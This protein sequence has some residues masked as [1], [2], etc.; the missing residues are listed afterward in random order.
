MNLPMFLTFA[1]G[2]PQD[3]KIKFTFPYEFSVRDVK[4]EKILKYT[5]YASTALLIGIYMVK[6]RPWEKIS[7]WFQSMGGGISQQFMDSK[8]IVA[9]KPETISTTFK[10][11]AGMHEAKFEITEFVDFLKEPEQYI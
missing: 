2:L 10:D 9:I 8:K 4:F 6:S 7:N 11:V 3:Y 5:L 1:E